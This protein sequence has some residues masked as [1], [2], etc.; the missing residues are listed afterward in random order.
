M[1]KKRASLSDRDPLDQL[2]T[3]AESQPGK[4]AKTPK[5]SDKDQDLSTELVQTTL[6]V[7]RDQLEWLD[8]TCFNARLQGGKPVS[9]AAFIRA[10]VDLARDQ[11][12][13]LEGVKSDEEIME[14]LKG[15]FG[16][17]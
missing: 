11:E 2:F 13:S 1:A 17:T 16:V 3:P 5:V 14:R 8:T 15:A 10:L 6:M 7:Y 4:P 9:K 12:V